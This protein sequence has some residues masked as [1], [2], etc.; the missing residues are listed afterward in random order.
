[1]NGEMH[2]LSGAYAVDALDELERARFE[3]HLAT[4][5]DCRAEVDS[6]ALVAADLFTTEMTPPASLRAG[7]LG[8]LGSVAQLPPL[9][10]QETS[11]D[12]G[13]PGHEADVP[14]VADEAPAAQ[15]GDTASDTTDE[16]GATV[17]SID[18]PGRHTAP[19]ASRW[20]GLVAAGTAA[21]LALGAFGVWRSIDGG[22]QQGS[23]SVASQ[24][25]D[26]SDAT[27]VE[28]TLP[29]GGTATIVRSASVGKAVLVASDLPAVPSDRTYQLWLAK[30]SAF[31]SAGLV[32]GA[33][34]QTVVLEGDANTATGAG[35]TVEPSGGSTQPTTTPLALYSF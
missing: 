27:R 26:A 23:P 3:R 20:R 32:P 33:G 19:R 34:N 17:T 1:M 31:T 14:D 2:A 22:G 25:L 11:P 30:G 35:I 8:R 16:N 29:G 12:A 4:C 28:K 15:A 6:L 10:V 21:V 5:A 13:R 24:V 9:P 7:V 18:R